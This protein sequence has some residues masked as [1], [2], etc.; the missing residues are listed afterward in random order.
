MH[1]KQ[2][3]PDYEG[4]CSIILFLTYFTYCGKGISLCPTAVRMLTVGLWGWGR[5]EFETKQGLFPQ[6]RLLSP[7][8]LS[9]FLF[10]LLSA[11]TT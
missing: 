6:P 7:A 10:L 4:I 2:A 3:T 1:S 5:Q 8:Q 11:G 9:A